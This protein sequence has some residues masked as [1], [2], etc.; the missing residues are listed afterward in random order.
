M[1]TWS[2]EPVLLRETA[3]LL[4]TNPDGT[5]LDATLG[6]GGHS[7]YFLEHKLSKKGRVIGIDLDC[8]AAELA[9]SALAGFA[10]RF[11][12]VR[13]SYTDARKILT[14]LGAGMVDGALFDLGLSS[15]QLDNPA[16][17]FSFQREGPLDMRFDSG[18]P[19]TANDIINGESYDELERI[20][21]VYG[22]EFFSRRI[23]EAVVERRAETRFETTAQLAGFIEKI[24]RRHGRTHPA[25][26]TF[27]ALRV[28]VNH[29]FEN[30]EKAIATLDQILK[31]GGRAAFITFHSLED[32]IIKQ[33]FRKMADEGNW[34]LVVKKPVQP[35]REEILKNPRSRSAKLRVIEKIPQI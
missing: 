27:Q 6:L 19:L 15:Y 11:T 23:A 22:E 18:N 25:T 2:H 1:T 14:S 5:Y 4:L 9:S 34:A 29:E 32:R 28:A 31:P 21:R 24:V 16:K 8:E 10:P 33:A 26:K 7:R 13:G 20:L 12:A 30:V 3:E 35:S 17:G